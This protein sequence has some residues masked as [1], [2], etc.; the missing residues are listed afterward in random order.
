MRNKFDATYYGLRL[1]QQDLKNATIR[2]RNRIKK[3]Q[4]HSLDIETWLKAARRDLQGF[5]GCIKRIERLERKVELEK[6]RRRNE[7]GQNM[8]LQG[9]YGK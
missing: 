2:N 5:K 9:T 8:N 6:K 1:M 3:H 4:T 7:G